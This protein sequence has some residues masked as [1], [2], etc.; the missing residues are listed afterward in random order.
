MTELGMKHKMKEEQISQVLRTCAELEGK[1]KARHAEFEGD[2]G[3]GSGGGGGDDDDD[4]D[5]NDGVDCDIMI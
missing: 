3:D 2:G 1:L 4:D 5:E